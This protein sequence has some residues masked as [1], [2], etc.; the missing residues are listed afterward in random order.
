MVA[1]KK[2]RNCIICDGYGSTIEWH[3]RRHYSND[4]ALNLQIA[5]TQ[6]EKQILPLSDIR[7]KIA[8]NECQK[9]SSRKKMKMSD[10]ATKATS[11]EDQKNDDMQVDVAPMGSAATSSQSASDACAQPEDIGSRI[12]EDLLEVNDDL[13]GVNDDLHEGMIS[14]E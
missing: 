2:E 10:A 1:S 8:L 12:I 4:K 6:L 3:H 11:E 9:D 7:V 5:S 14:L 13:H